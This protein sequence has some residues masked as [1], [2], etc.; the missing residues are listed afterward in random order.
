VKNLG[1]SWR[2]AA[3]WHTVV[4]CLRIPHVD[5]KWGGGGDLTV[6]MKDNQ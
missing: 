4:D 6:K 3:E 2:S 5:R 1:V